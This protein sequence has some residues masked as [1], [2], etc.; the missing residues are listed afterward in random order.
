MGS[1]PN[2]VLEKAFFQGGPFTRTQSADGWA[3]RTTLTSGSASVTVST[4]LVNSDSI[5]W[6]AT[7]PTSVGVN[8]GGGI[9]VSSIVS[10]KSFAF[11][12]AEGQGVGWNEV[13][14]WTL[15]R[16]SQV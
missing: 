11:A 15:I 1:K 8:S 14:T 10:G 16:T 3:D 12:R 13:I 4:A 7:V 5:F 9:V 2:E 6:M